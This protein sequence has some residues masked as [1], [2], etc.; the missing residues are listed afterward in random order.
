M[1]NI[2]VASESSWLNFSGSLSAVADRTSQHHA[3]M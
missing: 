3:L 1:E 2:Y